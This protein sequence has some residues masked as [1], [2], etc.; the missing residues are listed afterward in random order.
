MQYKNL[1]EKYLYFDFKLKIEIILI[2]FFLSIIYFKKSHFYK[3]IFTGI[4]HVHSMLMFVS[5]NGNI[6]R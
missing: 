6:T 5:N 4:F 2:L 1:L 3:N